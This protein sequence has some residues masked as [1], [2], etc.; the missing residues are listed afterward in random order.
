MNLVIVGM[1]FA[2]LL[3]PVSFA[4]GFEW[5]SLLIWEESQFISVAIVS[6]FD[7]DDKTVQ[8]IK[9]VIESEKQDNGE[10]FGWNQALLFI[11]EKTNTNIPLLKLTD[12]IGEA[13]ITIELSKSEGPKNV[14]G[15]TQYKIIDKKINKATVIIYDYDMLKQEQLELVVRHELGHALGLGHTYNSLDLMFPALDSKY[16]LISMFDLETLS[17]IYMKT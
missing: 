5:N 7:I 13:S 2:I 8:I 15:F 6:D 3:F 12:D 17:E 14:D 9:E 4:Q 11:S 1:I 10:F 16:S